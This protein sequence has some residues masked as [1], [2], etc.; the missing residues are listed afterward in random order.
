MLGGAFPKRHRVDCGMI[1]IICKVPVLGRHKWYQ[2]HMFFRYPWVQ[3]AYRI[4]LPTDVVEFSVK[5]IL[6]KMRLR[7]LSRSAFYS[8]PMCF[9]PLTFASFV[10]SL[11]STSLSFRFLRGWTISGLYPNRSVLREFIVINV[12][13]NPLL[14]VS[15]RNVLH[16]A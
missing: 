11:L 16:D 9:S 6:L 7:D 14:V 8:L 15:R 5:T 1:A 10:F 2:S 13:K 3:S 12:S 4:T